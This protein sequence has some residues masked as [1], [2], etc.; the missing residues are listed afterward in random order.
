MQCEICGHDVGKDPG[1]KRSAK[2]LRLYF[3]MVSAYF[4]HWPEYVPFQPNSS[5]HLRAWLQ[6]KAGYCSVTT[7]N[8]GAGFTSVES[9]GAYLFI[10]RKGDAINA[11]SPRSIA[12]PKLSHRDACKLFDAV[13]E[14]L[15]A[16]TGLKHKEVLRESEN[17]A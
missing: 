4:H 14:I 8:E 6:T 16:E 5:E 10:A 13:A 7:Y 15:E 12:F 17:A 11:Y 2:Q 3:A 1:C 9:E